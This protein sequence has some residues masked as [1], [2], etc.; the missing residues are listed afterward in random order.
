[1]WFYILFISE[2]EGVWGKKKKRIFTSTRFTPWERRV[3]FCVCV[4]SHKAD[5]FLSLKVAIKKRSW[6]QYWVIF[7]DKNKTKE[8]DSLYFVSVALLLPIC[9]C[10]TI[11]KLLKYILLF[12]TLFSFPMLQN[13]WNAKFQMSC[14]NVCMCLKRFS[15]QLPFVTLWEIR[16]GQAAAWPHDCFLQFL[17]VKPYPALNS[18][19]VY[20]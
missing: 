7:R 3:P 9:Y 19:F 15:F 16:L 20:Q 11:R 18:L 5:L 8:Q 13:Q 6:S 12:S 10:C 4:D 2:Q 14:G 17:W 1:M